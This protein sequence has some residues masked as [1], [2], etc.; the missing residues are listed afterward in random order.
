MCLQFLRLLESPS[1]FLA[2]AFLTLDSANSAG[3]GYS[4]T[5]GVT[6]RIS[7]TGVQSAVQSFHFSAWS[8]L[9]IIGLSARDG[10]YGEIV[11]QPPQ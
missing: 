8:S 10:A 5:I 3:S 11:S 9:L 1:S 7:Y 2:H 6:S 4:K